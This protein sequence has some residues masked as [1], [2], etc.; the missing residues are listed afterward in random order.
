MDGDFRIRLDW[1]WLG[2]RKYVFR[3][4]LLFALFVKTAFAFVIDT[5]QDPTAWVP[6]AGSPAAQ[7]AA[8]G[9]WGPDT[10]MQLPCDFSAIANGQ[11]CYWDRTVALDLSN[12]LLISLELYAS[13]PD[14]TKRITLH[15]STGNGWY[16][17]TQFVTQSGWQR[18]DFFISK[19][20]VLGTPSGLSPP[21]FF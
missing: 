21:P 5:F 18:L 11:R 10:L 16:E 20:H 12:D 17:L 13:H 19:M 14:A 8:G 7:M 2:I 3:A 15:F 4:C 1:G 9:P 6:K